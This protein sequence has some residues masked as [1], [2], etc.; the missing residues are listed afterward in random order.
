MYQLIIEGPAKVALGGELMG[1]LR[2]G[3]EEAASQ[4]LLLTGARDSFSAGLMPT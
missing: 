2:Q 1:R 4:P 3:I